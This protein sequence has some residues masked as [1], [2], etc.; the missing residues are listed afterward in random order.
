MSRPT[1]EEL[2]ALLREAPPRQ[3]I[4]DD[5]YWAYRRRV[6]EVLERVDSETPTR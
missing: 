6:E 5:R 1:Y 2:V 4:P 3:A